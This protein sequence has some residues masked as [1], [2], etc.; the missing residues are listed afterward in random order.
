MLHL[1]PERVDVAA[2]A[3]G[4]TEPI[5]DLLPR[6]RAAGVDAVA[7][8]GVLGDPTRATAADGAVLLAGLV[9][10]ARERVA[11]GAPDRLGCL[12][13]PAGAARGGHR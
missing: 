3:A 8:S 5:A 2:I 1:A 10:D 13:Q 7:P 9:A 4:N 6:L 12:R 11:A